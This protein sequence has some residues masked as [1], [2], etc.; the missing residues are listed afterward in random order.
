[1]G[2]CR[3]SFD[4]GQVLVPKTEIGNGYGFFAHFADPEGNRIGLHSMA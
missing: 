2:G 4:G 3:W 1:M